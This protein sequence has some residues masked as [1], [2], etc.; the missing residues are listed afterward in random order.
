VRLH[1]KGGKRHELLAH[2]NVAPARRLPRRRQL[3]DARKSPLFHPPPVTPA[4]S[5]RD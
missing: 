5:D 3:R 2:H 1:D 4:R